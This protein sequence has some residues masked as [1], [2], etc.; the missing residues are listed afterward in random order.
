VASLDTS[1][2]APRQTDGGGPLTLAERAH[3]LVQSEPAVAA[4]RAAEAL[5]LARRLH[6]REAVVAALHAL[7]FARFELG[8]PRATRTL[9]SAVRAADAWGL[10]ERAALA[11]R[12]LA[13]YLAYAGAFSD[14]LREVERAQSALSGL[15]R[16][17]TEVFRLAVLGLAGRA[18]PTLDASTRA[19]GTLRRAGDRLW[20]ARLLKNRGVLLSERGDAAAAQR[21]LERAR[22]LYAAAGAS[23]GA[24]GAEISLAR[25]ALL[26]GDI[27][28]CL[29]QLDAAAQRELP[30]RAAWDVALI[31]AE[32]LVG[33]RLL[34]EAR[35]ALAAG[36]AACQRAGAGDFLT[37]GQLEI[38]RL[39]LLA[40][41][42]DGAA[43]NAGAARR[44]LVAAGQP[45]Y[46]ARAVG[47]E[48]AA[49]L[50]ASPV[51]VEAADAG[52][53]AARVLADARW[54]DDALRL[55]LLVAR[56]AVALGD[57]AEA[58]RGL[59]DC[60]PLRRRGSA[61]DRVDLHQAEAELHLAHGDVPAA[62]RA[63]AAGC[64]VLD[65]YRADFG[66][67]ELRVGASSIGAD[68]AGIGVRLALA[69]GDAAGVLVWAERLRAAALSLPPAAPA[70]D[71]ALRAAIVEAR[72]LQQ[73][74]RRA[75]DR[76]RPTRTL[77]V[78]LRAQE[79]RVRGR[80]RSVDGR[81]GDRRTLRAT[82][83]SRRLDARCLVEYVE[84]DGELYAVTLCA[85][86]RALVSLGPSA[87]VA[88]EIEWLRFSLAR[89][90][91]GRCRGVALHAAVSS[92]QAA[93][94][95]VDELL[96]AP[97]A[98][99]PGGSL[100]VVPTGL[101]HALPW[102]MLPSLRARPLVVAPSATL[103]LH[104]DAADRDSEAD[105]ARVV[106]VAGPRLRHA[107]SEVDDLHRLYPQAVVLV[108]R[109]ATT[110]AVLD[111]LDGVTTAHLA[112][113]GRFRSDNPLFSSLLL[114]DGE[115]SAFE[116]QR[117]RR[118]PRRLVLSACSLALSDHRPGDELLGVA[119]ALLSMGTTTIIASAVPVSDL[120]TRRLMVA[121]HGR[122]AVGDAPAAALSAA[123]SQ[124][125]RLGPQTSG[126][127]CLGAG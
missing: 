120:A 94:A 113:H 3:A 114:A 103:W 87:R 104:L 89:C 2:P 20:E 112:C 58:Q 51:P 126:F 24:A 88:E 28:D 97:L 85:R 82:D 59:A 1:P 67:L 21:D 95:A 45:V 10:V 6:D 118:P 16:A 96:V 39:S 50:A 11:R 69:D 61:A 76:G 57:L 26:R 4:D 122:L 65:A 46:A 75:Q 90:A 62:R 40:G 74:I 66:A 124:D 48:L 22:E 77:H 101:L 115:L 70:D 123:Q 29:A 107:R 23:L 92:A 14:A 33:A 30:P 121:L 38:A 15:E 79:A 19:L 13:V 44:A 81:A 56:A 108:G 83:V 80:A 25:L 52:R 5:A 125:T 31:R 98:L 68:L 105:A 110:S 86:R 42:L 54:R 37:K 32:A 55:R 43:S 9:R 72:R 7:G 127:V 53:D 109:A 63:L 100:V 119:A 64:R 60:A 111:A 27:V 99:S 36:I 84:R 47:V 91:G 41:D 49:A 17:R 93:A 117:L 18:P 71:P 106:L 8:D 73:E 102:S 12:P 116:L 78:R 34:D 35:T